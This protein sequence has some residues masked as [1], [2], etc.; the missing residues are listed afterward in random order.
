M[1]RKIDGAQG[2]DLEL[3]LLPFYRLDSLFHLL[4]LHF[5]NV[6]H[7]FLFLV[8]PSR[9]RVSDGNERGVS[10]AEAQLQAQVYILC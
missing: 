6:V 4:L 2:L 8:L 9:E 3:I 7:P 1:G 10:G 5:L